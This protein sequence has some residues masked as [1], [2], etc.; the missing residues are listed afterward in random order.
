MSLMYRHILNKQ[1][2]NNITPRIYN[3]YIMLDI[4]CCTHDVSEHVSNYITRKK[5]IPYFIHL[6]INIDIITI[7]YCLECNN[8]KSI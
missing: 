5:N 8:N 4:I 1:H 3:V 2:C 7:L 6:I